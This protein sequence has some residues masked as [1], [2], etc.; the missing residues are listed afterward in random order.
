MKHPKQNNLSICTDLFSVIL[1]YRWPLWLFAPKKGL[2]PKCLFSTNGNYVQKTLITSVR[3]KR[4]DRKIYQSTNSIN[5]QSKSLFPENDW[6]TKKSLDILELY[7]FFSTVLCLFPSTNT[8]FYR[9][10][11]SYGTALTWTILLPVWKASTS[12]RNQIYALDTS[13]NPLQSCL[14]LHS[15]LD[16]LLKISF[17]ANF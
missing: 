8:I 12:T 2:F 4:W 15:I 3:G 13:K 1:V 9:D 17:W 11:V 6:F 14:V 16:L 5:L 10:T 7:F